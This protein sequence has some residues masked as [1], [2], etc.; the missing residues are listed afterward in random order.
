M[1]CSLYNKEWRGNANYYAV[2][3]KIFRHIRTDLGKR[4]A[5]P[6]K[7]RSCADMQHCCPHLC[8]MC[9]LEFGLHS[10]DQYHLKQL[11]LGAQLLCH[12]H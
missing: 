8:L 5:A 3:E 9:Q 11:K 10:V 4:M 2:C 1:L 7:H 12:P 6:E